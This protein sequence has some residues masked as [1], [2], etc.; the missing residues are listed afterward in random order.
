MREGKRK[1]ETW[2]VPWHL[3]AIER[4]HLALTNVACGNCRQA[5]PVNVTIKL[6]LCCCLT[7]LSAG[8]CRAKRA[9]L[10][11]AASQSYMSTDFLLPKS[12]EEAIFP[13]DLVAGGRALSDVVMGSWYYTIPPLNPVAAHL[14]AAWA[15][16]CLP[17]ESRCTGLN[18]QFHTCCTF[19]ENCFLHAADWLK[20]PFYQA[21]R[22][23][24]LLRHAN[25]FWCQF[26]ALYAASIAK[27]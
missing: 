4:H 11:A 10:R 3:Y 12:L 23:Q 2:W 21:L 20:W 14:T 9:G 27:K 19:P 13:G 24:L 16:H 5:N 25:V 18:P 15:S 26:R 17:L 1:R 6:S 8:Y 22:H 7:L